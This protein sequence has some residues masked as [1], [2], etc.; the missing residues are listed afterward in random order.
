MAGFPH[1]LGPRIVVP[2]N[3]M[4]EPHQTERVVLVLRAFDVLGHPAHV[5]DLLEHLQHRFVGAAVRRSPQRGDA[6]GDAR[7]RVGAAGAGEA[8]RRGRG[9]LLVIRVKD[10]DPVHR[11]G[12]HRIDFVI[13]ARVGEQH[14]KEVLGEL[15]LVS[16][17]DERLADGVLVGPGGDRRHLGDQ[18]VRGDHPVARIGDIGRIVIERRQRADDADHHRHRMRVPPE[19]L[20]KLVHLRMEHGVVGDVVLE[21]ALLVRVGK[22]PV[23]QEVTDLHEVGVRG[24]I[25]DR[26]AA[27]EQDP[28][29]AVD[30]GDRRLTASRRGI[31]RVE[32]KEVRIRV[33]A[34]D[35]DDV[36]PGRSA[37]NRQ[38]ERSP[39]G[40][41]GQGYRSVSAVGVHGC[42]AHKR[43]PSKL[44]RTLREPLRPPTENLVDEIR[45]FSI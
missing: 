7:E 18:A 6:R 29:I 30:E 16:R 1:D 31:A 42:V 4:T 27:I 35:V 15:E 8:D 11:L 44:R 19:P 20:V 34:A 45:A 38:F 43:V 39:G 37:E 32:G 24:E 40:V 28:G 33:E 26:V 13:L 12:Q 3:P 10:E 22:V 9:V 2:I 5:A 21:L 25:H 14:V 23:E 41:V 36:G 17:I